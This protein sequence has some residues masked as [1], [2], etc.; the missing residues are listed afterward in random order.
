MKILVVEDNPKHQ[1]DVRAFLKTVAG[2][3]P[4]YAWSLESA[5]DNLDAVDGVLCDIFMPLMDAQ[6]G[7]E[8]AHPMGVAVLMMARERKIPCV[9]VTAGYHHGSKYQPVCDFQRWLDA[10]EIVDG[11]H[12][13]IEAET[14][15]WPR[16]L[17]V[18][19]AL[20]TKRSIG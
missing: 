12:G 4:V 13:E 3:E 1:R 9:L 17:E 8:A 5:I 7:Q 10:P 16:G 14:K 6:R 19:Q 2:I 18:L 15:D 11:S 20:I